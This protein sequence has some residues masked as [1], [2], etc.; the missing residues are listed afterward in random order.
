MNYLERRASRMSL[1]SLK[2]EIVVGIVLSSIFLVT[3]L[4]HYFI[5]VGTSENA[6]LLLIWMGILGS[7]TTLVVPSFWKLPERALGYVLRRVGGALFALLL[8]VVYG[9]LFAP[10]GWLLRRT[11][12]S[13]PIYSWNDVEAHDGREGWRVKEV[14]FELRSATQRKANLLRRF[15]DVLHF[16][17]KRGHYVFLPAVVILLALGLAL[18]FV[19]SSALA[20]FI[21]TLF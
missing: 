15:V 12:G 16:F 7:A 4:W 21:Y 19:K 9:G 1:E 13:D 18:F 17:V 2:R 5:R 3:G 6:A 8:C 10:V 20:P 14:V 11:R